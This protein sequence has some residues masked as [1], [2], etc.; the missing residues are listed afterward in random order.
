MYDDEHVRVC[1]RAPVVLMLCWHTGPAYVTRDVWGG[2]AAG[3]GADSGEGE[4]SASKGS[5][6]LVLAGST[7]GTPAA[8]AK[9]SHGKQAI[10]L[11]V[12][13]GDATCL[14]LLRLAGIQWGV[15][16]EPTLA[17]YDVCS[18][19]VSPPLCLPHCASP[20]VS[21]PL[22]LLHCASPT[23]PPPLCLPHCASPT[24]PAVCA[25]ACSC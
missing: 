14:N 6:T 16:L 2:I 22:C 1:G 5:V 9:N 18:P 23:V 19:T 7:S 12:C 13:P 21:P 11:R 20:T 3:F 8:I 4:E 17:Y 25:P 10:V 15:T 24:V